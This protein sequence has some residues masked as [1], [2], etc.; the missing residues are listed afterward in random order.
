MTTMPKHNCKILLVACALAACT[1]VSV[2]ASAQDEPAAEVGCQPKVRAD[3]LK[4][5][6]PTDAAIEAGNKSYKT[7]CAI[8]HGEAGKGDGIGGSALDP[9]P[10]NFLSEK[11]VKTTSPL[12][13]FDAITN[14]LDGTAMASFAHIPEA[15]RWGMVHYIRRDF[16]PEANR[17][18]VT[19]DQIEAICAELSAPPK[20][21]E[22]PIDLAM[23]ILAEENEARWTAA[24]DYGPVKL[25]KEIAAPDASVSDEVLGTGAAV[26][27]ANCGRCHGADGVGLRKFERAGRY[28]F[29]DIN[30][31]PLSRNHAG[32][33]WKDFAT[34][35]ALGAHATLPDMG[36]A[37]L[38]GEKQWRAVHAW[39]G[40]LAA[41]DA[42]V[43]TDRPATPKN[44]LL[45]VGEKYELHLVA[46]SVIKIT[47]EGS[48]PVASWSD[49]RSLHVTANLA[50]V[51]DERALV[52]GWVGLPCIGTSCRETKL[53]EPSEFLLKWKAP[54][55][56]APAPQ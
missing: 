55:A 9:K 56:D 31:R 42:V 45:Y 23:T 11:F 36:S 52:N 18:N 26:Y 37:A 21:P 10:R 29:V 15:D 46:G 51:P 40:K 44:A 47:P 30:T 22:I 16:I 25:A 27:G 7:N 12:G 20:N 1:L 41:G 28:P 48:A 35:G 8:C 49:V 53:G 33:T 39:V 4:K 50:L 3:L 6:E 43:T 19:P 14:G 13:I 34:R 2:Q 54:A 17:V 38:L 5:I 24:P 32:G